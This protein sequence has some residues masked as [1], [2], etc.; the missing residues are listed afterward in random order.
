MCIRDSYKIDKNIKINIDGVDKQL[1]I[2]S[3]NLSPI[4][5]KVKF[6]TDLE[7]YSIDDKYDIEI[8]LENEKGQEYQMQSMTPTYN[9]EK[10]ICNVVVQY[11][12]IFRDS[13]IIKLTPVVINLKTGEQT[14]QE[15]IDIDL[16][17]YN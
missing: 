11:R 2:D 9:E 5:A 1:K 15:S 3:L 13:K 6:T 7:G 16:D 17:N 4:Y 14:E 8:K 12:N 10:N